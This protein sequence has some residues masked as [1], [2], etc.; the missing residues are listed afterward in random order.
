[1]NKIIVDKVRYNSKAFHVL[2]NN[3]ELKAFSYIKCINGKKP[4]LTIFNNTCRNAVQEDLN[5]VKFQYFR[6][7]SKKGK[8]KCQES[9]DLC[10]WSE[11]VVD[12][13]QPNTFSIIVDRFIEVNNIDIHSTEY[14]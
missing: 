13:R 11:L 7:N 6:D 14:V 4:P 12:H 3:S 1:I 10:K 9:G 2:N 8:V 5:N